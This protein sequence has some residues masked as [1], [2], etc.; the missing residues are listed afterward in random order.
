MDKGF[1]FPRLATVAVL[2]GALAWGLASSAGAQEM[3]PGGRIITGKGQFRSHCAQC[4][5][6]DGKG[7]G[8]VAPALKVK[9][10]NLT[11]LAKNNGGTFPEEKV[12]AAISGTTQVGAHG[13][14]GGTTPMP[15]WGLAF[16]AST[17]SGTG[18]DFTP[19]EVDK[20]IKL[21]VDYI[22]TIQEK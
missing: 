15:V 16:R 3:G 2:S 8:Q 11:T 10:A 6:M 20:K 22:K 21:L 1:Y 17:E 5:G 12:I 13:T 19:E 18:A 7:D 14:G 4:H 9:P